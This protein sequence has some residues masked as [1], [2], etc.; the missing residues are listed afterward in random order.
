MQIVG[1]VWSCDFERFDLLYKSYSSV[2]SKAISK[3]AYVKIFWGI[4]SVRINKS[5]KFWRV[6]ISLTF[7]NL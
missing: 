3:H 7:Q 4:N 2:T 5:E 1:R 6:V